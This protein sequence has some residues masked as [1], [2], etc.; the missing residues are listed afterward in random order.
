MESISQTKFIVPFGNAAL[1]LNI[2]NTDFK[3]AGQPFYSSYPVK[4]RLEN[5]DVDAY[6]NNYGFQFFMMCHENETA[7]AE[8]Q[9]Y[10]DKAK[11]Y[12]SQ[13]KSSVLG[14]RHLLVI[15][16]QGGFIGK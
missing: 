11:F 3:L 16:G 12:F 7:I 2:T 10:V 8:T 15:F 9:M 5:I 4:L 1:S 13:S 6:R 14:Q